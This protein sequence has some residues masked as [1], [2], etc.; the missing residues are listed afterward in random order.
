M[1]VL[2]FL[3]LVL[4]I[5]ARATSSE[6]GAPPKLNDN[7]LNVNEGQGRTPP[8]TPSECYDSAGKSI[9]G[10]SEKSKIV[11]SNLEAGPNRL[12]IYDDDDDYINV[13]KNE[14]SQCPRCQATAKSK[15]NGIYIENTK[16]NE[17]GPNL[18]ALRAR[19]FHAITP[20]N[21]REDNVE[22]SRLVT[23]GTES[24]KSRKS[25][26]V[27]RKVYQEAAQ[28][29][30]YAPPVTRHVINS[31]QGVDREYEN[32][33]PGDEYD[34]LDIEVD[35]LSNLRHK[36][37]ETDIR[38][39]WPVTPPYG[40]KNAET[41][42]GTIRISVEVEEAHKRKYGGV[43]ERSRPPLLKVNDKSNS[44]STVGLCPC[45]SNCPQYPCGVCIQPCYPFTTL[46]PCQMTSGK[47]SP[48]PSSTH[49]SSCTSTT[50]ETS[51]NNVKT[52]RTKSSH[53]RSTT[54]FSRTNAGS[55]TEACFRKPGMSSPDCSSQS[56]QPEREIDWRD[57][58]VGKPSSK[59]DIISTTASDLFRMYGPSVK[60]SI[61]PSIEVFRSTTP[62][63]HTTRG[64]SRRP[65]ILPMES[66]QEERI[67]KSFGKAIINIQ[68]AL[69]MAKL[70]FRKYSMA[71]KSH[72]KKNY[73]KRRF[74]RDVTNAP[75]STSGGA[76]STGAAKGDWGAWSAW[77][78]CSVTCGKGTQK[79]T[80][81]KK[82]EGEPEIK[83]TE[84]RIC[85][86]PNCRP[87][88]GLL[89]NEVL[90][91]TLKPF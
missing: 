90:K 23:V 29:K 89:I 16:D 76:G 53:W 6:H 9:Q 87:S 61:I 21:K 5:C 74:N 8:I 15:L 25:M 55:T 69:N 88:F 10:I 56:T 68:S 77:T 57:S 63:L 43:N 50:C 49:A 20:C 71:R 64:L 38:M 86:L 66:G 83:E 13:D 40:K 91:G 26:W 80:R 45:M 18:L 24:F 81:S 72:L 78:P 31:A 85:R 19:Q 59:N 47:M 4:N 65:V 67:L 12:A 1:R 73:H 79:R 42:Q 82:I 84:E 46:C 75:T 41:G 58:D 22:E 60:T 14:E 36:T 35:T 34:D 2:I 30:P 51:K 33:V 70:E 44:K 54:K 3:A 52:R 28:R 27:N 37:K 17:I 11:D 7:N 39:N 48:M 32:W 62:S